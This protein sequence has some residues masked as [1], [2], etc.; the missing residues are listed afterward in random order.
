MDWITQT[1]SALSVSDA[2]LYVRNI[3]EVTANQDDRFYGAYYIAGDKFIPYLDRVAMT[4]YE[5][6]FGSTFIY[7]TENN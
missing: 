7:P 4:D 3:E 6:G 5:K 1:E 2:Y